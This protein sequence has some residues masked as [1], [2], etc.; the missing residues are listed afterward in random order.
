[1]LPKWE[2]LPQHMQTQA[3]REYYDI[4]AGKR[5][6]LICKRAL[7]ILASI[8]LILLL[9]PVMAAVAIVV[10]ATSPGPAL[11]LQQRVT[12]A[13]RHFTICK[14]RTMTQGQ[15]QSGLVTQRGDSRITR[16]GEVLRKT[17]LDELPQLFNVLMGEMT[18]VGTRPEVPKYVACYTAEMNA[19]LL[20]PAGV[21][22]PTSIR[23]RDEEILLAGKDPERVYIE[24]VLPEKMEYNLE[25]LR[26]F[27]F[28]RDIGI[29]LETVWAVLSKR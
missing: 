5:G 20:L 6:A 18:F 8:A 16:A 2:A 4:L 15:A 26:R 3:V 29:M 19:T 10:K 12:T 27:S 21:T 25:Y 17:R 9:W 24:Q 22:S 28:W 11:F 13:G 23:Y 1:M 14:F 7:D